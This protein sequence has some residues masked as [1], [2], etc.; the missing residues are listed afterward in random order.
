ML[1]FSP[2]NTGRKEKRDTV[3]YPKAHVMYP[4]NMQGF[5]MDILTRPHWNNMSSEIARQLPDPQSDFERAARD[6]YLAN[7]RARELRAAQWELARGWCFKVLPESKIEPNHEAIHS[8][9]TEVMTQPHWNEMSSEIARQLPDPLS[10]FERAARDK[11]LGN[12]RTRE[13]RAAQWELARGWCFK[14]L[15]E[16]ILEPNHKAI[17]SHG[18]DGEIA[19]SGRILSMGIGPYQ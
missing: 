13:L 17:H 18:T 10:D 6:K 4:K 16:S 9:E 12:V 14:V 7:V 15:P 11:Y 2:D 5:P 19:R 3:M 8:Y 1:N